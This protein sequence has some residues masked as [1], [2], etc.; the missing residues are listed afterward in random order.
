M[1]GGEA[2]AMSW[3]ARIEAFAA[4]EGGD[5]GD[6]A[7]LTLTQSL[8]SAER[9]AV[10]ELARRLGL[11]SKS[12]GSDDDGTRV[13]TVFRRAPGSTGAAKRGG[14]AGGRG[15]RRANGS[16][17]SSTAAVDP[18]ADED[19]G[20]DE[21]DGVSAFDDSLVDLRDAPFDLHRAL[22]IPRAENG[23]GYSGGTARARKRRA[24]VVVHA[25]RTLV[26]RLVR[27]R[28]A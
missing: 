11:G 4:K 7:K 22:E 14:R 23:R 15:A 24:R 5:G 1:E 8:S 28:A 16:S 12:E 10:H 27:R 3:R 26:R 25:L 2:D 18:S 13:V 9:A 20:D 19:E 21:D 17:P 6:D